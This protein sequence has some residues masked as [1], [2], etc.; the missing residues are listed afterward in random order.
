[1][2]ACEAGHRSSRPPQSLQK[3]RAPTKDMLYKNGKTSKDKLMLASRRG[4]GVV[5]ELWKEKNLGMGLHKALHNHVLHK[6]QTSIG[7]SSKS[8]IE[9][10]HFN[11]VVI[12]FVFRVK[13]INYE[14]VRS[15]A[16]TVPC[17]LFDATH[18]TQK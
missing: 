3:R 14:N 9:E 4:R 8:D 18:L 6:P 13:I 15:K 1:M 16:T 7:Q 11:Q 17:V 10:K 12:A 5:E 2:F